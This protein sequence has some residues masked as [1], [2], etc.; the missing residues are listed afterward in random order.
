MMKNGIIHCLVERGRGREKWCSPQVFSPPSKY[1]LS[2]LE[3]KLEWK[4][5]KIFVQN[6]PISFNIFFFLCNAAFCFLF[7]FSYLFFLSLGSSSFPSFFFLIF[8][9]IIFLKKKL[10]D[11]FLCYFL[12]CPLLSIHKRYDGKFIQTLFSTKPK[13]FLSLYFSTLSTKHKWE[14]LKTFLSSHF[15]ILPLFSILS[16]FHPSNQM[17][18]KLTHLTQ[19]S[20][21]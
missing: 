4:V 5:K 7:F 21:I 13:S 11:D 9:F 19:N 2:K 16:F 15:S 18:P 6:Y 20:K 3:R 1:N 8:I 10:L 14:K 12:K 17:D